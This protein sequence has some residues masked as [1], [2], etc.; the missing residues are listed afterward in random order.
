MYNQ[1]FQLH[2][3]EKE[4]AFIK[5]LDVKEIEKDLTELSKNYKKITPTHVESLIWKS[6][7][8][9]GGT[10]SHPSET[11]NF[12]VDSHYESIFTA[13]GDMPDMQFHYELFDEIVEVTKSEGKTQW[14]MEEEPVP[15]HVSTHKF[16]H[17]KETF[18]LFIAPSINSETQERF[19]MNS[20]KLLSEIIKNQ[21]IFVNIVPISYSEFLKI[22]SNCILKDERGERWLE[23]LNELHSLILTSN[24]QQEWNS[25]IK[26]YIQNLK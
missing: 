1:L 17:K 8:S 20:K 12:H 22:Y 9:L 4:I 23:I 6:I 10:I 21:E 11:R 15:R 26:N 19:F 3:K 14:K 25:K 5:N 24:N 18:C 16:Y 13:A 2:E 7:E